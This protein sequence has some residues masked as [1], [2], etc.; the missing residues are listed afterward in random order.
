MLGIISG[1]VAGLVAVTPASGFV[2]PTGAFV[3]GIAAGIIC[4]FAA[5]K[6]KHA[7]GYDDS[8]DAFGVHGIGG[9]VGAIGTAVVYAPSLGG[10]G[11]ADYDMGAKLLVQLGAVGTTIVWAAIGTVIAMYVAKAI[12]GLRV[13]QE[14]EQEGLD[15]GEHGERAY[16]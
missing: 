11:A 3:I 12:T 8:L 14:V 9:M 7:L 16:N 1:V 2:N 10:P 5:V 4:Y 13:S 15:L 6:I